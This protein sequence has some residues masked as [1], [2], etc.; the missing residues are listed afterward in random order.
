M[1]L[2][3]LPKLSPPLSAV[4][5]VVEALGSAGG[6]KLNWWGEI[7]TQVTDLPRSSVRPVRRKAALN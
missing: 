5:I 6:E 7:V 1:T 4:R 2:L 3:T